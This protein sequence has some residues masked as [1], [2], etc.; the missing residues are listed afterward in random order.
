MPLLFPEVGHARVPTA[1]QSRA[2]GEVPRVEKRES[3]DGDERGCPLKRIDRDRLL[4]RDLRHPW[5][6]GPTYLIEAN[7]VERNLECPRCGTTRVETVVRST[8]AVVSRSY[9]Y[10]EGYLQ[11]PGAGR[12]L[13][14]EA[15]RELLRTV[16]VRELPAIR[17]AEGS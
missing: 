11:E 12:L 17:V 7:L 10:P 4:C 1:H 14:D 3:S 16:R 5:R 13:A 8:G 2:P 15:R 9:S 6:L